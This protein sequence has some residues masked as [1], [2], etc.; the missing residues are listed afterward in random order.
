[1]RRESATALTREPSWS[2]QTVGTSTTRQPRSRAAASRST[3]NS[4]S[5]AAR[6]GSTSS[7]D[8]AAQHLRAALRVAVRQAHQHAHAAGEARAGDLAR[9]RPAGRQ[10]RR[11]DGG[12]RRSRRRCGARRRPAAAAR[13]AASRSRRRR[14]PTS[15]ASERENVSAITPALAELGVFERP[16]AVVVARVR[17]DDLRRRVGARVER[18]EEADAVVRAGGAIRTQRAIDPCP[19]RCALASRCRDALRPPWSGSGLRLWGAA[20][21]VGPARKGGTTRAGGP[22]FSV[23]EGSNPEHQNAANDAGL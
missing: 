1:M 17:A 8:V 10:Q 4:R 9:Q 14:S 11:R 20:P 6:R 5:R 22:G 21:Q 13:A 12:A 2:I 23:P 7:D 19:P 3:S 18:D 15:S 16:H